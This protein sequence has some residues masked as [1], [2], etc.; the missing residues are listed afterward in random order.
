MD[1]NPQ[2]LIHWVMV[3]YSDTPKARAKRWIQTGRVRVGGTIV[4]KPH[5]LLTDPGNALELSG[6]QSPNL[7]FASGWRIHPRATIL[8]LD[9]ALAVINKGAGLLSVPAMGDRIS[10]LSVVADFLAGRLKPSDHRVTLKGLPAGL[11]KLEPMAVHR[12]DQYTSG[13]FCVAM[14]PAARAHLIAQVKAHTMEREYIAFVEGRPAEKSGTWRNWL[15]LD[16]EGFRQQ[17]V[18]GPEIPHGRDH[19]SRAQSSASIGRGRSP[20]SQEAVTHY[21]VLDEFGVPGSGRI[22]SKLRLRLETGRK[23][24]I[25]IQ[26]AHAGFPLIGDRTYNPN[27]RDATGA[28][29]NIPFERQALHSARLSLQHPARPGE[30][31]T[32]TAPLPPDLKELESALR[33]SR[34]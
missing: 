6:R 17:V 9:P 1:D 16:Q 24:Q 14:N 5:E 8:F 2:P 7:D 4:R 20:D 11:R 21:E 28:S 23:H 31:R 12:L 25:R 13:V 27:Y 30:I 19:T 34:V 29:S 10:V 3:K 26:A 18:R 22:F 32:W 33:R 15:R